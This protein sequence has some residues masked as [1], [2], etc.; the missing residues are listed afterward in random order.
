MGLVNQLGCTLW[1]LGILT[2]HGV[3]EQIVGL[4]GGKGACTHMEGDK[5]AANAFV[6]QALQDASVE[7]Q[8]GGRGR[9]AGKL[10]GIMKH[11][12]IAGIVGLIGMTLKVGRDRQLAMLL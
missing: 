7:M 3:I 9:H 5:G 1:Q 4:D 8:T 6:L 10:S 11:R 2:V 12:L